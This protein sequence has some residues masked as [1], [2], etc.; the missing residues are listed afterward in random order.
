MPSKHTTGPAR[1]QRQANGRMTDVN[2][3]PLLLAAPVA[4]L[5]AIPATAQGTFD[6]GEITAFSNLSPTEI[7]RTGAT[8]DIVTEEE[9]EQVGAQP[10]TDFLTRRAGISFATNGGLGA[11]APIR[12]RGLPAPYV[13]VRIDGIDVTDPSLPQVFFDFGRL[14]TAD[15]SRIEIVKG[16]QSA[17]FGSSAVAGA[18]NIT[19]RRATD[20]GTEVN[21]Q[22]EAGSY[23]SYLGSVSIATMT[24]RGELAFTITRTTTDGFSA[25][26]EALGNTE[27]DGFQSTRLS[28]YGDYNVTD[29]LTF[30]LTG[31]WEDSTVEFDA[32]DFGTNLPTDGF[33][34]TEHT[35]GESG[36]IRAFA[37][38]EGESVFN[39]FSLS[40][41]ENRRDSDFGGG[42]EGTF[43]GTRT[44]AEYIGTT[45]FGGATTLS[46]GALAVRE[47][48]E[49]GFGSGDRDIGAA[50]AE[51]MIAA[52]PD[53]DISIA[54]RYDDYSDF[55]GFTS[56][57]L[58]LAYRPDDATVL[59]GVLSTGFRAP[60]LF[61]LFDTFSG[62]PDLL[63]EES[64]NVEIGVERVFAN[65][66]GVQVTL[67]R[68]D[69][70]NLIEY[71]FGTFAYIQT[72]GTSE[73]QGVELTG[74]L[75]VGANVELFGNYTYTDAR[76]PDGER[77]LRV[78]R[79]DL[80][81]GIDGDITD[82]WNGVFTVQYATDIEDIAPLE[83]YVVA[84]ATLNYDLTDDAQVYFRIAN[85]FDEQYQT[86]A[87]YGT[88]DRAFYV[89]LRASF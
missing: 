3:F 72:P 5:G 25:A 83:D 79:N 70:D 40:Y 19:T 77:L 85:L 33:D 17:L 65:G 43:T 32:L 21:V 15:V 62:N 87:G 74:S 80:T 4:A 82:R 88:S 41:F 75:P 63:A 54:A 2:R 55:G 45:S 50:F 84:N 73:T 12:V 53:T 28:F 26:D 68:T 69:I 20:P 64:T 18:I 39:T 52:N 58:A 31:F 66:A 24:E 9:L 38:I 86:V 56:G 47:E 35:D 7:S 22:V 11:A 37:E 34:L 29:T 10:L 8:V 1:P 36:G 81:V 46:F 78:P 51:A 27:A 16:S 60:S 30:G 61:E 44:S 23:S 89:G 67:F 76:G 71:D 6:L 57:R 14:T 48:Y 49:D 59:R 42:F 13:A